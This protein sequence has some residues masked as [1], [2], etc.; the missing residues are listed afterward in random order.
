MDPAVDPAKKTVLIKIGGRPAEDA[1]TLSV[2]AQEVTRLA[3]AGTPVVIV[4]GGGALLSDYSKDLGLEPVFKDGIRVTSDKEMPVVDMVL[5]GLVNK[6]LVRIFVARGAK[7]VGLCGADAGTVVGEAIGASGRTGRPFRVDTTLVRDLLRGGYLPIV[8]P[9]SADG[10]GGPL[11]INADEVALALAEG[12]GAAE[13]IFVSDVPGILEGGRRLL[14]VDPAAGR[15]LIAEGVVTAGM[16][17]KLNASFE[18][19]GKGVGEVVVGSYRGD[20]DLAGLLSGRVGT[21][22]VSEAVSE[23]KEEAQSGIGSAE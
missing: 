7:A 17:P 2:F 13:L 4:H 22:V 3:E 11:N 5:A 19:L 21:R 8:A 6:T 9:P 20:G 23:A 1:D 16:I 10:A 12:L 15:R 18:A 14:V